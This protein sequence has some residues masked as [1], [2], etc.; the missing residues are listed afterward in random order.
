[1]A[2]TEGNSNIFL[3]EAELRAEMR[4]GTRPQGPTPDIFFLEPVYIN[5]QAV[6]WIDAMLYYAS[7]MYSINRIIPNGELRD[8]AQRFNR[9][10]GKGAFVLGQSFCAQS[11]SLLLIDAM[12][13]DMST[14]HA[15]LKAHDS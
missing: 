6:N 7:E 14:V 15:F 2:T 12:P 9:Y 8:Q 11:P 3:T 4:A 5:G 1:M 10:Y 13:L